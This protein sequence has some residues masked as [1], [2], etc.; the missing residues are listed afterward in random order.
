[1]KSLEN[2]FE[3]QV[4]NFFYFFYFF[5]NQKSFFTNYLNYFNLG[6]W[7]YDFNISVFLKRKK[8]FLYLIFFNDF[9]FKKR[10]KFFYSDL[11]KNVVNIVYYD[12]VNFSEKKSN[13]GLFNL[14][15]SLN[16]RIC[17]SGSNLLIYN[18]KILPE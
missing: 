8:T 15:N 2:F 5:F 3:L 18:L 11:K 16:I 10:F 6:K 13:L 4:L 7:Y 17:Y 14:R 9:L 1:M 12:T